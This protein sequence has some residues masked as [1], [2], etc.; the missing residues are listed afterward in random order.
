MKAVSTGLVVFAGLLATPLANPA[1]RP[2]VATLPEDPRLVRLQQFLE[3]KACPA[4][5][6]AEEF[7]AAADAYALDWRLL[8]SIAFVES[9]GGK[10]YNNNNILGWGNGKLRFP[11]IR[12]GIQEVARVLGT[13][14]RYR[15]KDVDE[16]L[17][18]FNPEHADYVLRVKTVMQQIARTE[19]ASAFN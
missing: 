16:I 7:I 11:S 9:G 12:A 19:I 17:R 4:H 14:P 1:D 18:S 15:D 5:R 2:P 13:S 10:A 8:P 6:F 3:E